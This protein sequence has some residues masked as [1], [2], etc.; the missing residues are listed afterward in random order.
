MPNVSEGCRA[1]RPPASITERDNEPRRNRA[2][3]ASADAGRIAIKTLAA[4]ICC[5]SLPLLPIALGPPLMPVA[6]AVGTCRPATGH[7]RTLLSVL[8]VASRLNAT[9]FTRLV[10]ADLK[11][12]PSAGH[13]PDT[14]PIVVAPVV[15][16]VPPHLKAT[17]QSL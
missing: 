9:A 1:R 3:S 7:I 6:S 12:L 2:G 10:V 8:P 14:G 5:P 11:Q 16:Q 13:V 4:Q 15:S 17:S